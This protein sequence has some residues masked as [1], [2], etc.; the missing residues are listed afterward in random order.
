[1]SNEADI[2]AAAR[3]RWAPVFPEPRGLPSAHDRR[4]V[5]P[6]APRASSVLADLVVERAAIVRAWMAE[7]G[8]DRAMITTIGRRGHSL[9]SWLEA[10]P[11][12]VEG[13]RAA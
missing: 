5:P 7:C 9:G 4:P 2:E 10:R 6:P 1:M 8:L 13:R 11:R 3:R 12:R